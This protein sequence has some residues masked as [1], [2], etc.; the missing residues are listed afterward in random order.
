MRITDLENDAAAHNPL[1]YCV[2]GLIG[3]A[4]PLRARL[5]TLVIGD[6][7]PAQGEGQVAADARSAI[8]GLIAL[9]ARLEA[10]SMD[11][12]EPMQPPGSSPA[13]GRQNLLR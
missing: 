3:L 6:D 4:H 5:A 12:S 1:L 2:L 10:L 9:S 7:G 8:L 13:P 11:F